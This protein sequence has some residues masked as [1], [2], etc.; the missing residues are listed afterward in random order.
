MAQCRICK[1][2]ID[3]NKDDWIMPSKNYYYHRQCYNNWKKAQPENDEGYISLIYDF[4][5]RELKVSYNW[6]VCEAQRKKFI[7]ENKVTNKGILFALKY[8]YEVKHGDWNKGHGGI[9]IIPFI[10]NDSC[11]YWAAQ[12]RRTKGIVDQIEFQMRAAMEQPKVVIQKKGNK[13]SRSKVDFSMLDGLEEEED[14]SR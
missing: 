5:S 14:D 8:F 13:S 12:E 7:K 10:Y 4:I 1:E 2:E 3:K 6:H 9:G 11:A